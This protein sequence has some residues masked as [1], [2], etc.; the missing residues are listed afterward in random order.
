MLARSAGPVPAATLAEMH[1][2]SGLNC[3]GVPKLAFR[4]ADPVGTGGDNEQQ[5]RLA[6]LTAA[7]GREPATSKGP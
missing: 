3:D 7:F 6:G 4:F 5:N 1:P 2:A